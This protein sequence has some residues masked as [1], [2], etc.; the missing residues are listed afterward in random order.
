MELR[1]SKSTID[2]DADDDDVPCN[3]PSIEAAI[4]EAMEQMEEEAQIDF[5]TPP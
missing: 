4:E 5:G 1:N 3:S 2:P